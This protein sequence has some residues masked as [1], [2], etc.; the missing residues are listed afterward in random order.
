[1][2]HIWI[3]T[4]T[5]HLETRNY[6]LHA[7]SDVKKIISNQCDLHFYECLAEYVAAK[8]KKLYEHVRD[9]YVMLREVNIGVIYR[10][11][12]MIGPGPPT[13]FILYV[14]NGVHDWGWSSPRQD[15][16]FILSMELCGYLSF[17]LHAG[18]CQARYFAWND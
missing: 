15:V 14:F 18:K 7:L 10:I 17:V 16:D 1:M 12:L 11:H 5:Q 3:K 2:A 8:K 6:W 9:T 4:V 13:Q